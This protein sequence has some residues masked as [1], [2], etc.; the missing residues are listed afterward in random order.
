MLLPGN[1]H[2]STFAG[3]PYLGHPVN[4]ICDTLLSLSTALGFKDCTCLHL[5]PDLLTEYSDNATKTPAAFLICPV[6]YAVAATFAAPADATTAPESRVYRQ[7]RN[8][9]SSWVA[10]ASKKISSVKVPQSGLS[11]NHLFRSLGA[12]VNHQ[13]T[14]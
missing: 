12:I 8:G 14:D 11:S 13:Q 9:A 1:S 2:L 4:P 5:P 7:S 3:L 6:A 10:S